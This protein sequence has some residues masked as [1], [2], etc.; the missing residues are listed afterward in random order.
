VELPAAQ[1]AVRPPSR[2][3]HR[4]H[5]IVFRRHS[6]SFQSGHLGSL[7][8][9][10]HLTGASGF[11]QEEEWSSQ[12]R[13]PLYDPPPGSSIDR[14]TDLLRPCTDPQVGW[15]IDWPA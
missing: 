12:L 15:L 13:N 2:L 1:P 4:H 6:E 8:F 3:V 10:I 9:S 14:L 7:W 5:S 11:V